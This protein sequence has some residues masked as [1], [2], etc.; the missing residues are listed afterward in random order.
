MAAHTL[1][2][3]SPSSKQ[4]P[5]CGETK[6]VAEFGFRSNGKPRGYCKPCNR[7]YQRDWHRDNKGVHSKLCALCGVEFT[8]RHNCDLYCSDECRFWA[9]VDKRGPDDCWLW[10]GATIEFGHG[11]FSSGKR[12]V[13]AHRY[14]WE[15][16]NGPIPDGLYVLH[17]CDVPACVNPSH[18]FLGTQT[19]NMADMRRKGRGSKP[20]RRRKQDV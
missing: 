7:T 18:L 14:S 5:L 2:H 15:M 17:K 8:L 10:S 13:Y 20:P 19:E 6:P 11:Q 3:T 12:N 1:S 16:A 4:C 9:K